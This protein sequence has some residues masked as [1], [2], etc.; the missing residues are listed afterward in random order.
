MKKKN[1]TSLLG[2]VIRITDKYTIIVDV[3]KSK[4]SVG[5]IVQ[6]YSIGEPLV[7]LDEKPL[8]DFIY[9]KDTLDVIDVQDNY[10]VCRKNKKI[11]HKVNLAIPLSPMLEQTY[12]E[13]EPLFVNDDEIKRMP[14]IDKKVHVG[15]FIKFA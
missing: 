15:D 7:G 2:H 8:G 3:G 1:D 11:M 14:N 10:S 5:D 12:T 13:R 4:L 6:I 9:I